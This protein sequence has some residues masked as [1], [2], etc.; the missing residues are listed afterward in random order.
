MQPTAMGIYPVRSLARD[1]HLTSP[2]LAEYGVAMVSTEF[3]GQQGFIL[4]AT[5]RNGNNRASVES[6]LDKDCEILPRGGQGRSP[7]RAKSIK[8]TIPHKVRQCQDER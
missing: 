3:D 2:Q 4:L 5:K 7:A 8:I 1:F 6:L